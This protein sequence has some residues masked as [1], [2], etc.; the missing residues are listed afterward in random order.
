MKKREAIYWSAQLLGWSTY[1]LLSAMRGY[2]LDSLSTDLL[3]LLVTTFILGITLSHLY[4]LYIIRQK[5]VLLPLPSLI[6][7]VFF[8]TIV[9]GFIFSFILAIISD[10]FFSGFKELIVFP[11]EGLFFLTMNWIVIFILWSALY[12]A[13]KFLWNY[14]TEEIKN[15]QY[16]ALNNEVELNNLKSQLNPHFMFNSMNSIRALIDDE[17]NSAKDAVTQLSNLLRSS[18]L[19]SKK[20]FIPLAEELKLV[21]DY[22]ALEK[23]RYEE[24]LDATLNLSPD[25]LFC[26]VPPLMLQTLVEN[27]IKHGISTLPEGGKLI[28][29]GSKQSHFFE[30]KV[31]NSGVF[32]PKKKTSSTHVG[33]K[34]TKKRLLLLY[35]N[36]SKFSIE[37]I[38][39]DN[40]PFVLTKLI[41]PLDVKSLNIPTYES[42]SN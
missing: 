6:G 38:E 7:R 2:L 34:N 14:R 1:V 20:K 22:L 4:R 41:L 18:L 42:V 31:I 21:R 29:E 40:K 9:M 23:I 10:L 11:F 17:P 13:V 12:F 30:L 27:S 24:R 36:R 32:N 37:N 25:L 33:L 3:K 35:G 5:W 8:A 15:L 28:I 19:T 16:Q 39:I 26:M